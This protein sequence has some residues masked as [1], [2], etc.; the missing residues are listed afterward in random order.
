[1][2]K[3]KMIRIKKAV[4][5]SNVK[6]FS[7]VLDLGCGDSYIQRL[8][9][10]TVFYVGF[11]KKD[12]DLEKDFP[13][14][15][16]GFDVIFLLEFLEHIENF[17]TILVN[18]RDSLRDSGRI[19]ISVP[20]TKRLLYGD[21]FNGIGEDITHIHSFSKNNIRNLARVTGLKIDRMIGS[22]L[23]FPPVVSKQLIISSDNTFYS[24]NLI[25]RLIKNEGKDRTI[26]FRNG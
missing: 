19:I 26:T 10:K 1:M 6:R 20:H 21:I 7:R 8:L 13:H 5:L 3:K 16:Y 15:Y 2:Q 25:M 18:C 9:P 17:K 23:C 4:A 12:M 22:C 11:D 24:E 14:F